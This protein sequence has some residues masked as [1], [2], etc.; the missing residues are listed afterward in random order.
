MDRVR[1]WTWTHRFKPLGVW[2]FGCVVSAFAGLWIRFPCY[3]LCSHSEGD[4][5]VMVVLGTEGRGGQLPAH[6]RKFSTI[7]PALE[8]KWSL[9]IPAVNASLLHP[10][11]VP[12]VTRITYVPLGPSLQEWLQIAQTR[13]PSCGGPCACV[14]WGWTE[15]SGGNTG[16]GLCPGK[17][18]LSRIDKHK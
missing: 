14:P 9:V 4:S 6:C 15:R 7:V 8:L 17:S 16:R 13:V 5:L 11:T 2:L 18:C 12:A 10:C 1:M 3:P